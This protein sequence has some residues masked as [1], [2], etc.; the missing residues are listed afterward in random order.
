MICIQHLSMSPR[1]L[2]PYRPST[3][4]QSSSHVSSVPPGKKLFDDYSN[5]SPSEEATFCVD[6]SRFNCFNTSTAIPSH[7]NNLYLQSDF[8]NSLDSPTYRVPQLSSTPPRLQNS[9]SSRTNRSNKFLLSKSI[10]HL[11][12]FP[13]RPFSHIQAS[14]TQQKRHSHPCSLQRTGVH[15]PDLLCPF[16]FP[17]ML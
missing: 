2:N 15:L 11:N 16:L 9:T 7:R 12:Y 4:N 5:I 10:Y 8:K 3:K 14:S 6:M 13:N 17:E 1:K